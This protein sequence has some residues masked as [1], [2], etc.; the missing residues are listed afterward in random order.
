M[1]EKDYCKEYL[2]DNFDFTKYTKVSEDDNTY[3]L[4]KNVIEGLGYKTGPSDAFDAGDKDSLSLGP[5]YFGE[6]TDKENYTEEFDGKH[7]VIVLFGGLNGSGNW[8]DYIDTFAK[9]FD[10]LDEKCKRCWLIE[11]Q[12]DCADDVY[13]AYIGLDIKEEKLDEN[14]VHRSMVKQ[15]YQDFLDKLA[16]ELNSDLPTGSLR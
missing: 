8:K 11:L 7:Y 12:N 10:A 4:I 14:I 13:T 9:V 1:A 15:F 16:T 3:K 2:E 6:P 5:I